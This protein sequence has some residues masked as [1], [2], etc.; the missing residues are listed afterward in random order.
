MSAA[1]AAAAAEQ[2]N[3]CATLPWTNREGEGWSP[4]ITLVNVTE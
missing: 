3:K 1:A 2:Q 4:S